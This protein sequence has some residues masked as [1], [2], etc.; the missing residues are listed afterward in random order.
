MGAAGRNPTE[1]H[2]LDK[3]SMIDRMTATRQAVMA[4]TEPLSESQLTGVKNRDGWTVKDILAHLAHW[5]GELVT[6]LWELH[7]GRAVD[8]LLV[9]EPI[10]VDEVN[11]A[12]AE[13]DRGRRLAQV[14][15]DLASVRVQT[16]RRLADFSDAD[17]ERTD[18]HPNL[19]GL[20]LW[21]RVAAN[22]YEH[23][24]EHI[25]DLRARSQPAESAK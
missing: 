25:D 19:G 13:A 9:R 7:Q 12:W 23:D 3:Q 8:C 10:A 16:L 15:D 2:S 14:M 11:R 18:L 1:R 5:E 6:L 4:A 24:E 20:A 22:T 21:Y 17:M